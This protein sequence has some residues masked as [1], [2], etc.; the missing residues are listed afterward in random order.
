ML[1]EYKEWKERNCFQLINQVKEQFGFGP[2]SIF[3]VET[4][5]PLTFHDELKMPEGSI[6]GPQF[7][8]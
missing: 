4:G 1:T 2:D 3:S 6:Y 8:I 7:R 5:S